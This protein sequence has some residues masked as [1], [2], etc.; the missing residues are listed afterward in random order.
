ML[1]PTT[2]WTAQVFVMHSLCLTAGR[3]NWAKQSF[4]RTCSNRSFS[5]FVRPALPDA[6]VQPDK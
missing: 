1:A 5:F 6:R 4:G 3:W 2:C